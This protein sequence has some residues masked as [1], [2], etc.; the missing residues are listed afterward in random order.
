MDQI[1]TLLSKETEG[2]CYH[3]YKYSVD[4]KEMPSINYE[5]IQEYKL[6]KDK[7]GE[8]DTSLKTSKNLSE[9]AKQIQIYTPLFRY[10][11]D[12]SR[13]VYKVDDIE[14]NKKIFPIMAGQVGVACCERLSPSSFKKAALEFNLVISLP[15]EADKDGRNSEQFFN[16]VTQKINNLDRVKQFNLTFSKILPYSTKDLGADAKLEDKGVAKIQDELIDSEKKIVSELVKKNLLHQ[17]AYLLKDGS[18]QYKPMKSGDFR[19]LS[20]LKSNYRCVVGVSKSFN[21]EL[22]VD[23]YGRNAAK[24]AGLPLHH[25]TPAFM[26]QTPVVGYDIYFSI[27]YLRIREVKYCESPFAGVIKIEKVLVTDNEIDNGLNSDEIDLISANIINESYPV[28]YGT[29][30]RW[31]NHLYSIYLTEKYVKSQ[32]ISD[33]HFLNLF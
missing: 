13:R 33:L 1:L 12:G 24:I 3:S 14:L 31:A 21:P 28:A 20:K 10:F 23:K 5:E 18:L 26:F 8:T 4:Q 16:A 25:R 17:D 7:Y 2:K 15:N 19:E 27:W 9:K 6:Q 22:S 11:L 30:A 32:H 29:D